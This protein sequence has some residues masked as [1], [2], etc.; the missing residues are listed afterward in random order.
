MNSYVRGK[1]QTFPDLFVPRL[2]CPAPNILAALSEGRH[3]IRH[4]KEEFCALRTQ[5]KHLRNNASRR[6]R[7]LLARPPNNSSQVALIANSSHMK[8]LDLS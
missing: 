4:R 3:G 6:E 5:T 2:Y 1:G 7:Q 8:E